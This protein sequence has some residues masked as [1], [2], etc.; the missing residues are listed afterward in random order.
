MEEEMKHFL[1]KL[2]LCLFLTCTLNATEKAADSKKE[3]KKEK[4]ALDYHIV[5]TATRT[6][7]SVQQVASST[8]VI[9]QAE[10]A[11][12]HSASVS[13]AIAQIPGLDVSAT[14]GMGHTTHVFIRGAN[15]EHTLVLLDGMEINDPTSPGRSFDFA[16]LTTGNL[17]RIEVVRGPQSTLYGSD[18]M[19]GVIQLITRQGLGKPAFN[20]SL[21]AGSYGTFKESAGFGGG[22]EKIN[23]SVDLS[24]IDCR[25]FSSSAEKYGN[26]EA[27]AY[28]NTCFSSK[29]GFAP[30]KDLKLSVIARYTSS[31]S[32][33]DSGAGVNGDDPNYHGKN[34]HL[35]LSSQAR[36][37]LFDSRWVQQF[38]ISYNRAVRHYLDEIDEFHPA[39][40]SDA[41][42]RGSLFKLDWQHD[43]QVSFG[44][45]MTAGVDYEKEIGESEYYYDSAW[46]PGESVFPRSSSET[47]AVYLQDDLRLGE[48]LFFTMGIRHDQHSRFGSAFTF[49]LAP[50]AVLK[51][52]TRL[53]ASLGSG[54]KSPSLYQLFAPATAW[55]AMGNEALQPEESIG[56][57]I[58]IEQTLFRDNLSV[59]LIYFANQFK[60]LIE[61]DWSLGYVNV[62]E[63]VSNGIEFS[64]T[65]QHIDRFR[66]Q[67]NYTLTD[68]KNS[69][70]DEPLLRRPKHKANINLLVKLSEKLS[71][72]A[73]LMVVGRRD[74]IYPYPQR[75]LADPYTVIN[76]GINYHLSEKLQVFLRVQNLMDLDYESVLGYG[77]A[78]RSVY[79]GFKTNL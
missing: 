29:L 58:G 10:M 66:L 61:Y 74:D 65:W 24:R 67:G 31:R 17:E 40:S 26:S 45:V 34:R 19:G 3:D 18:A 1:P 57:D 69:I 71:T 16:D 77:T 12:R 48:T 53:K 35:V 72:N 33:L 21:E 43:L 64:L 50:G 15:A 62:A 32:D 8:D 42:Y 5:V 38:R 27:D 36:Y 79:F 7:Q 6:E 44:Q 9:S 63:A 30:L 20:L 55:S 59:G 78:K 23:Y 13:H 2:M 47:T 60:D 46:G 41:K 52:G 22:S 37:A 4:T 14:G 54:F 75:Q 51:S 70:T 68:V 56:F 11:Q 39:D 25:G 28:G 49:R 73:D 76:V